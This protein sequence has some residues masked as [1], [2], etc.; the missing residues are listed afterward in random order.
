MHMY[1]LSPVFFPARYCVF[2]DV[3][4]GLHCNVPANSVVTVL[5]TV[6]V[7][8][9]VTVVITHCWKSPLVTEARTL[10]RSTAV[11]LHSAVVGTV[12]MPLDVH[13]TFPCRSPST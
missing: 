12:K 5:V 2:K 1:S 11:F 9:E 13:R 7:A 4:T 10:L 8:V 6:V 3:R